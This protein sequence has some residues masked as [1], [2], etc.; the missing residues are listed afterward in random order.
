MFIA[1][2]VNYTSPRSLDSSGYQ[3]NLLE[4][5]TTREKEAERRKK[6]TSISKH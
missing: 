4:R 3:E 6:A 2:L 1:A 5:R